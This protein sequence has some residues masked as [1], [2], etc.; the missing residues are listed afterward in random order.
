VA[1]N[2][3][4]EYFGLSRHSPWSA[5]RTAD[6]VRPGGVPGGRGCAEPDYRC[7]GTRATGTGDYVTKQTLP[8]IALG[9]RVG[10]V[11]SVGTQDRGDHVDEGG[12]VPL[13]CGSPVAV[14]VEGGV[15]G[16]ADG[17]EPWAGGAGDVDVGGGLE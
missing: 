9:R 15:V 5:R 7:T 3:H 12:R 4:S 10:G 1:H 13:E 16:E 17:A 8:A 11:V 2:D 14:P 6:L